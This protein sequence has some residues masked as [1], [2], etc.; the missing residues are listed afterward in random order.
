MKE[1][2]MFNKRGMFALGSSLIGRQSKKCT[3][4]ARDNDYKLRVALLK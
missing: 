2:I 4:E 3:W 1:Y